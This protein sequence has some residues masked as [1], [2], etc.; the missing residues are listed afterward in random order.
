MSKSKLKKKLDH[1]RYRLRK[2]AQSWVKAGIH[3]PQ[4]KITA[5]RL[6]KRAVQFAILSLEYEKSPLLE[7]HR[8]R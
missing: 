6:Y 5:S 2:A 3:A 8:V 4:K 1:A 7:R